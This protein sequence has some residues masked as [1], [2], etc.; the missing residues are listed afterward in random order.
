MV[1]LRYIQPLS[2][3]SNLPQAELA[4]LIHKENLLILAERHPIGETQALGDNA[5]GTC[6]RVVFQ[7][8]A[9]RC[10]LHDVKHAG[11]KRTA[12]VLGSKPGGSIA[13]IHFSVFGNDHRIGIAD[14]VA[15][16]LIGENHNLSIGSNGKQAPHG[17][18]GNQ[19]ALGI[20]V[21]A[22]YAS[23]GFGEHFLRAPIGCHAQNIAA[24]HRGV[25][26]AVG[27]NHDVLWPHFVAQIN[28]LQVGQPGVGSVQT[29]IAGCGRQSIGNRADR[30]WP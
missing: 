26:L 6:G 7:N 1:G 29:G 10:A 9:G 25:E 19:V 16:H 24:G 13:E 8:P 5:G 17:I 2:R 22:Q 27:A 4:G 14:R 3:H 30:Y 18:G 21:K 28:H 15:I 20:K 23:A 12:P 11:L